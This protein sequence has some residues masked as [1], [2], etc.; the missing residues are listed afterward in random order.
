MQIGLPRPPGALAETAAACRRRASDVSVLAA[1]P[2]LAD[3]EP[4]P[5]RDLLRAQEIFV[6]R[7][8]EVAAVERHQALIAAHVRP[9]ID[10]HREMALAEQRAG[11][12]AV[13]QLRGVVAR[14]GAQPIRRLEVRRSK[15]TPGHRLVCRMKR[16]SNFSDEPSK[17]VSTIASP[18]SLPTGVRIIV[19][20]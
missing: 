8:L 5:G 12:L 4:H 16:P 11:I 3:R 9:L 14:I 20:G 7:I 19:L 1:A 2:F 15:T 6:R 17:V 13:L 10:G 18:S